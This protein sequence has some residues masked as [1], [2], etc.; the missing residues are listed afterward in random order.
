M[1]FILDALRRAESERAR[2]QVPG[3]HDQPPLPA[4]AVPRSAWPTWAW[5]LLA[6][7]VLLLAAAAGWWLRPQAAV[8]PVN[9]QPASPAPA[10]LPAV[11]AVV[12]APPPP[13]VPPVLPPRG[14]TPLLP[15]V[16]SAPSPVVP[17]PVPASA[18][19]PAPAAAA[20]PALAPVVKL[21]EMPADQRR[22]W[23]KLVMGGSVWSESAAN[24][25]VIVNGLL[26]HEGE[27]V[28][29]GLVVDRIGPKAVV[30]RWRDRRVEVPL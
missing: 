13:V 27:A 1:S 18:A 17:V 30:L 5:A 16:V 4:A 15:Q 24:R 11:P 10:V 7:L 14:T 29:P 22:D 8:V 3:L 23:P 25:F 21:A 6:S 28:A 19:A 12:A 20:V 9:V 2:G 26:L